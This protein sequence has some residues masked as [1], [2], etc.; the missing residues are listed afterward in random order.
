LDRSQQTLT[1]TNEHSWKNTA[2][3]SGAGFASFRA[4][5]GSAALRRDIKREE[6]RMSTLH[7]EKLLAAISLVRKIDSIEELD[8]L[9]CEADDFLRETL[10]CYDDG[11][12]EERNLSAYSLVLEQVHHAVVDRRAAISEAAASLPRCALDRP[13]AA[14][15]RPMV[16]AGDDLSCVTF[17]LHRRRCGEPG[18]R[19]GYIFLDEQF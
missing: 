6:R 2:T 3:T 19:C 8:A 11:A 7:R 17:P 18:L 5:S 14:L 16:Q 9:Q 13:A 15:V 12:I 4:G 10:D 1:A